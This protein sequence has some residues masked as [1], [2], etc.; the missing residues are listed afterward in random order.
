MALELALKEHSKFNLSGQ[1]ILVNLAMHC[2]NSIIIQYTN[3]FYIQKQGI[4][5]GENN[6]VSLANISMHFIMLKISNILN[7]AQ[8]FKRFIDNIIW[9]SYGNALTEKN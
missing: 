7:Q 4:I 1:H 2:L 3:K 9:L 5:T 6:S 8:L